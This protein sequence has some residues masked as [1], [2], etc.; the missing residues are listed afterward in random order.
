MAAS[1]PRK[2]ASFS[3]SA[4]KRTQRPKSAPSPCAI[5]ASWPSTAASSW[6]CSRA[7]ITRTRQGEYYLTD[8]VALAAAEGARVEAVEAPEAELRG[9]NSRAELARGRGRD[10]A[11]PAPRRDGQRRD[12]DRSRRASSSA[13]TP[14]RPGRHGRPERRLRA[15]RDGGGRGR[16]PRLQPPG[17]L[18]REARRHHRPLRAAAPGHGDRTQTRM[19]ATSWS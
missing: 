4:R 19:S 15:G 1:S 9:I 18:R 16:D 5:P 14:P 2:A 8:V 10:A 13:T 6:T 11:P 17:R 3:P 12:A 7:S